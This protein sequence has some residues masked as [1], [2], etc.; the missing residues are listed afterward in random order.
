MNT[1]KESITIQSAFQLLA[2]SFSLTPQKNDLQTY[3]LLPWM[4]EEDGDIDG[5]TAMG[6]EQQQQ[7]D[8]GE[9]FLLSYTFYKI[10][11]FYS[12]TTTSYENDNGSYD[13]IHV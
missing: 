5:F 13:S 4:I 11:S 7:I 1:V 8:K 2:V 9:T 10:Y 3:N 12:M 6:T